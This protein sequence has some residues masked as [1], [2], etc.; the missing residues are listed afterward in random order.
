MAIAS[1]GDVGSPIRA[2]E[3][4]VLLAHGLTV[5]T[6]Q[7]AQEE[8]DRLG[9]GVDAVL[10]SEGAVPA[11]ALYRALA[12]ACGVPFLTS[13]RVMLAADLATVLGSGLA[14]LRPGQPARWIAAPTGERLRPLLAMAETGRCPAGLALTTPHRFEWGLQRSTFSVSYGNVYFICT[15]IACYCTKSNLCGMTQKTLSLL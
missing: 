13:P 6:L 10:L 11:D 7:A 12:A 5:E 4:F 3:L 14:P 15:T 9:V 8:A 2:Q 1:T